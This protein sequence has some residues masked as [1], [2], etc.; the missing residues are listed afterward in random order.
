[1]TVVLLKYWVQEALLLTIVA[2]MWLLVRTI[3]R[4][5]PF[6]LGSIDGTGSAVELVRGGVTLTTEGR[7]EVM[8]W[9]DVA[10]ARVVTT[11]DGP[12]AEDLFLELGGGHRSSKMKIPSGAAGFDELLQ[13]IERCLPG[14]DM[15]LVVSAIAR[16]EES[17]E[18]VW[19]KGESG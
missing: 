1:V 19:E 16:T 12:L 7:E 14:F 5:V 17:S 4:E 15:E 10:V 9:K 8:L 11:A 13:S 3:R 18:V 2:A 6:L